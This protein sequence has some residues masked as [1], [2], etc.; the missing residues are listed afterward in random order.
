MSARLV[1]SLE[2][3]VKIAGIDLRGVG[4]ELQAYIRAMRPIEEMLPSRFAKLYRKIKEGTSPWAGDWRDDVLPAL[5]GIMDAIAEAI[6]KGKRGVVLMKSAQGGGS[7]AMICVL[8]WLLYQFPGPILYLIS[9]DEVAKE[10]S[11]DRFHYLMRNCEP[12]T[13]KAL[14]GKANGEKILVK[15]LI[16]G[17]VRIYGGGSINKIQTFPYRFVFVDEVDSINEEMGKRGIGGDSMKTAEQRTS[18]QPGE[19]LIIAFAHPTVKE[20]GAG[21]LYYEKSD[22]RRAMMNCPHCESDFWFDPEHFIAIAE[23][24]EREEVARLNPRRYQFV[25]PCCGCPLSEAQ[26]LACLAKFPRQVSTLPEDEADA[27]DWIGLHFSAFYYP[28]W[29]FHRIA[30]EIIEG[31]GDPS[32][33]RVVTNKV[34]GDVFEETIEETSADDWRRLVILPRGPDDDEAWM[35][36]TVPPGV[37]FMTAGQDSRSTQLHWNVWG[38][39]NVKDSSGLLH[40]CGWLID[41]D[42]IEREHSND[43]DEAD[44]KPLDQFIYERAFT[45]RT[46]RQYW[47]RRGLHDSGWRPFGVYDYCRGQARAQPCK[48]G[49]DDDRSSADYIQW[50]PLPPYVSKDGKKI[51]EKK[52]QLALLNVFTL[53][54][55][56]QRMP[57]KVFKIDEL[58]ARP[59]I[60]LPVDTPEAFIDQ[61]ASEKLV[62]E[63]RRKLWKRKGPNHFLDCALYAYAAALNLKPK[64]DGRTATDEQQEQKK[65]ARGGYK[66][67]ED[68]EGWQ[69]GR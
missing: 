25:L 19:T 30:R 55:A 54:E 1:D 3:L 9:T 38:W 51:R 35:M 29:S 56:W 7:E 18:A 24:G 22:Q 10:F 5:V 57:S 12:I 13:R 41:C 50:K 49:S 27:K 44:L 42:I 33:D 36:G 58:A 60:R 66:R 53:R 37:Q 32:V 6:E 4:A 43:L 31:L 16:D 14:L 65:Q 20:Q 46:S 39:G 34:K 26:R 17:L 28:H 52:T 64:F 23:E 47:V 68:G 45:S 40:F 61:M 21:K 11:K 59:V 15:N 2:D 69:V 48:G 62:Q 8:A 63:G 67:A